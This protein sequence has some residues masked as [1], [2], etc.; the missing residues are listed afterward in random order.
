[1]RR[2]HRVLL[3]VVLAPPLTLSQG[4]SRT[5]AQVEAARGRAS[6]DFDGD[7]YSD[8]A[9]GVPR[10]N[11][12]GVHD[13]G[14]INLL[15]GS[16]SGLTSDRNQLWYEDV[17]GVPA[18]GEPS[19]LWGFSLAAADFD[20]DGYDDLAVGAPFEDVGTERNAGAVTV[21][22]G[23]PGGLSPEGAQVLTEDEAGVAGDAEAG[24]QLG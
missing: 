17:P 22:F 10:E 20:G 23:S 24:D 8:L 11:V 21:L 19:D 14:A 18:E 16:A 4:V 6:S 1:M 12:L 13:V 15:Y 2:L 9:L 5:A 3:V 7:G